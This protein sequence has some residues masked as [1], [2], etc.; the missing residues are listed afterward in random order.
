MFLEE[1]HGAVS[2]IRSSVGELSGVVAPLAE[3]S[4]CIGV[5]APLLLIGGMKFTQ[6]E[7]D[8]LKP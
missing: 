3:L 7:I 8:G 6:V 4:R 1:L 5:I 2:I